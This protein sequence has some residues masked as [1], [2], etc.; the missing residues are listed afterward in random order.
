M[1]RL[2]IV[3]DGTEYIDFFRLFLKD[4]HEY[5]HAQS[6]EGALAALGADAVAGLVLDMRFDRTPLEELVGDVDQV[7][8]TYFGGDLVRGQR[9]VQDNQGTMILARLREEGH[10]APALFISDL[11]KRKLENL[12]KLYGAVFS[13]PTFDAAAI[14]A[15]LGRALGLAK[16]GS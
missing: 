16:E 14:R 3:E 10:A 9:Y 11:P 13:V 8:K 5:L 1:D 4:E 6:C 7:A 15:E 12:R 2:L